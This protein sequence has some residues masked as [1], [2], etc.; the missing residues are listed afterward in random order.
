LSDVIIENN[1]GGKVYI[2]SVSMQD[3]IVE[4]NNA[5]FN[6]ITSKGVFTNTGNN[7]ININFVGSENNKPLLLYNNTYYQGLLTYNVG[8]PIGQ[9]ITYLLEIPK[10]D[11]LG[12]GSWFNDMVAGD[13][14]FINF[15]VTMLLLVLF[16]YIIYL[17][18]I[19]MG[20]I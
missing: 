3:L 4:D 11:P 7:S 14:V 13:N 8:L 10:Y 1:N 19:A 12:T 9:S 15:I 18:I 20:G 17:S 5:T 2:N 6:N 16:L